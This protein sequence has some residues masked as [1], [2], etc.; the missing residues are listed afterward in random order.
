[1]LWVLLAFHALNLTVR[2]FGILNHN[3]IHPELIRDSIDNSGLLY[4]CSFQIRYDRRITQPNK[5]RD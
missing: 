4:A 5:N 3:T 2:R 1:M